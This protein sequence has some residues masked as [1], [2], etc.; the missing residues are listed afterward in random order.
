MSLHVLSAPTHPLAAVAARL[1]DEAT[2]CTACW[3][4]ALVADAEFATAAGLGPHPMPDPEFIDEVAVDEALYGRRRVRLT[5]AEWT[6][7]IRRLRLADKSIKPSEIVERTRLWELPA[8]A[9][10]PALARTTVPAQAVAPVRAL[11]V[12]A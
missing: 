11:A 10:V 4:M 8:P 2:P 5:M 9:T 1:C 3:T 7:A 12:A 6:E